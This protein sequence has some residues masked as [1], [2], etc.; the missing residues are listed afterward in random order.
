[1]EALGVLPEALAWPSQ[2]KDPVSH[3]WQIL[4]KKRR[5]G[6]GV[7]GPKWLA[8]AVLA[9]FQVCKGRATWLGY[10]S[11]YLKGQRELT[12]TELQV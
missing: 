11:D 2:S 10:C 6:Q 3:E 4:P 5:R 9:G 7:Q 1:M 12:F 8:T